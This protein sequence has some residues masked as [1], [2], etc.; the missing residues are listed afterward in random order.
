M[1]IRDLPVAWNI[2]DGLTDDEA[3]QRQE[4][5]DIYYQI[6][7]AIFEYRVKRGLT[8]KKLAEQLGVTQPMVAKLESGDYNYTIEQLWKIARRLGLKFRV[9]FREATEDQVAVGR[10]TVNH[11]DMVAYDVGYLAVG[12]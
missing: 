12:A 3:R 10:W 11:E 1:R 7:M 9:E 4:L 6:S 5:Y 8:Q 2:A